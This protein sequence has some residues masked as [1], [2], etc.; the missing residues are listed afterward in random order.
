MQ[1]KLWSL[2]NIL[3]NLEE[4]NGRYFSALSL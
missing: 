3:V 2:N 4:I 1:N